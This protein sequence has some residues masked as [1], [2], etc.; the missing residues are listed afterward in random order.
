MEVTLKV[1]GKK[2]N[3]KRVILKKNTLIGRGKEC[4]L[5]IVSSQVSRKHCQIDIEVDHVTVCDLGSANGTFVN[6]SQL[7]PDQKV[8]VTPGSTVRLGNVNFDLQYQSSNNDLGFGEEGTTVELAAYQ[9]SK[10]LNQM[11]QNT[12]GI[13]SESESKQDDIEDDET[14]DISAAEVPEGEPSSVILEVADL[15]PIE[16]EAVELEAVEQEEAIAEPVVKNIVVADV[17]VEDVIVE[18]E[19]QEEE[20]LLIELPSDASS[21]IDDEVIELEPLEVETVDQKPEEKLIKVDSPEADVS[22]DDIADFLTD[23]DT[24]DESKEGSKSELKNFLN[25]FE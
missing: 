19:K 16:P 20:N 14:I 4:N 3:V 17:I 18:K 12:T 7:M 23:L 24:S 21:I 13:Q 5:Q 6:D 9:G 22:E 11:Q 15:D 25:Q 8:T 10:N 2:S 1:I